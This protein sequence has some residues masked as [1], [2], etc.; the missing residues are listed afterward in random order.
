MQRLEKEEKEQ[1]LSGK[2]PA[3]DD[4]AQMAENE[5]LPSGDVISGPRQI[6]DEN[7]NGISA[8]ERTAQQTV[9]TKVESSG[10]EP[11]KIYAGTRD[12]KDDS[13]KKKWA[14]SI[15]MKLITR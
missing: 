9:Q 10:T 15:L 13:T 14:D 3:A 4:P 2:I 7:K 12:V 6:V 1:T 8:S 5:K 11:V